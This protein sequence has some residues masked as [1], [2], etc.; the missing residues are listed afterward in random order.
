V[1]PRYADTATLSHPFQRSDAFLRMM[2]ACLVA[3]KQIHEHRIV[4][5]DIKEDNICIPYAPHPFPGGGRP[6]HLEYEN[7]KLI[8]FAFAVAHAIPLTQILVINPDERVPYQSELLVAALRAD[9]RSGCPN[10]VQQLDYR[11]DLFSLGFMAEKISAAGLDCP[12][13]SREAQVREDIR[14]LVQALKAFDSAAPVGPLP[15]DGLIAEIDRLLVETA[16]SSGALQFHVDGEWTAEEMAQGRGASRPTPLTPVASP[17]ATPVS[18]PLAQPLRRAKGVSRLKLSLAVAMLC[19]CAGAAVLLL[20]GEGDTALPAPAAVVENNDTPAVQP[21][22]SAAAEDPARILALLRSDEEAVFQATFGNLAK[23]PADG[24]AIA[25][26]IAAEYAAALASS[27]P[28]ETRARALGR[29][30]WM[31]K[32][33]NDLAARRVA[34]FEKSYD[35]DKSSV[36]KSPWWLRGEGAPPAEAISWVQSGALLAEHGDRPAM[37]DLAF[38]MGHGRGI[39]QD[40]ARSVETYLKVMASSTAGDEFSMRIRQSAARGLTVVLNRIVEQKDRDAAVRLIPALQS[41]A[42][43]GA[44]GMQYYLGLF[45]ECVAR[46][47]NLDAARQ[48]YRK[49]AADPEWRGTVERKAR[50]LGKWC[51][52]PARA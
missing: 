23:T 35:T 47:A 24:A 20:P 4:H 40:R 18:A 37:L 52:S 50:L 29:L 27:S 44:A 16:G 49:A 31:A 13:G 11:V 21:A 42:D 36:A 38:A 3:L 46:P 8:D 1:K 43:A 51:P 12:N 45:N 17:L 25:E 28:L 15:H 10:A 39:R 5:C 9:R 48:W 22:P 32:A 41:N 30:I 6:I 14:K 34:A 26:S 2:R 19:A 7:L 33:G